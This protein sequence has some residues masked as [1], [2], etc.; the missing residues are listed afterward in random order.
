[1]KHYG[2]KIL[3]LI[4]WACITVFSAFGQSRI[5]SW[6]TK[7]LESFNGQ[8]E[9]QYTWKT[10]ASRFIASKDPSGGDIQYPIIRYVDAWPLQEFG[11]G[12]G[13]NATTQRSL[14]LNAAF[15]R[16][17]YNWIDLYPTLTSDSDAKPAE[18]PMPGRVKSIDCWVWGS[19]LKY[20]IEVF[21]RDYRGV[22]HTLKLGDISF[23][24]WYNL[25]VE[26]STAIPQERRLLPSYAGLRFIKFRIWTLPVE[27][28]DS[29]YIYLKQL[30][31]L[32]DVFEPLFDGSD[33]ADPSHV[34][35]LWS[36]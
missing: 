10:Q 11:T 15:D 6:D 22:V 33:L 12:R 8:D 3:C 25:R 14:G 35:E 4:I 29:F 16:K 20:Y 36:N 13:A 34:Q 1:M 31:I 27:R 7:I 23:P 17:G 28:V 21:I 2:F 18:I 5:V 24:G 9:T 26:L 19:N 30:R 32:T